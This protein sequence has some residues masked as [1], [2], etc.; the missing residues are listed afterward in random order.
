M[1]NFLRAQIFD[2]AVDRFTPKLNKIL[3]ELH[4]F[5]LHTQNY[6]FFFLFPPPTVSDLVVQGTHTNLRVTYRPL[7]DSRVINPIPVLLE[8]SFSKESVS[9]YC[10]RFVLGREEPS[11]HPSL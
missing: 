3:H 8:D 11:P 10:S 9:L 1:A 2:M 7:K 5:Y 6:F 4:R